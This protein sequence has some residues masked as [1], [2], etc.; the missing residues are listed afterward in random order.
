MGEATLHT[1]LANGV[2]WRWE[3]MSRGR[4]ENSLDTRNPPPANETK[5]E[6]V[7]GEEEIGVV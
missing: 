2:S 6:W 5:S 3:L 1:I 7:R 4:G